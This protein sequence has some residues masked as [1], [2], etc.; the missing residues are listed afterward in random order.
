MIPIGAA[1]SEIYLLMGVK[2]PDASFSGVLG[3]TP[4][5]EIDSPERLRFEIRYADGLIDEAFPLALDTHTYQVHNGPD[6]YCIPNL[7]K[8]R[9]DSIA[10]CNRMESSLVSISAITLNTGKALARPPVPFALPAVVRETPSKGAPVHAEIRATASGYAIETRDLEFA[11][12]TSQ[13]IA[14]RSL[15]NHCLTGGDAFIE[16]G[17]LFELGTGLHVVA[18]DRLKTGTA[19]VTRNDGPGGVEG[20]VRRRYGGAPFRGSLICTANDLGPITLELE[21]TYTGQKP[22]ATIVNFPTFRGL[23]LGTAADTWYLWARKGGIIS[24][25]STHQAGYSGGEYPLQVADLFNP[26]LGGGLSLQTFDISG[27]YKQWQLERTA[28]VRIGGSITF[29]SSG[30]RGPWCRWPDVA[31]RPCGRLAGR[32]AELPRVDAELVSAGHGNEAMVPGVFQL[33]AA[34]GLGRVV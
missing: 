21:L 19:S 1:G 12:S 31:L 7:R 30:N 2:L 16:P 17:P 15:T 9:I 32:A 10:I 22:A 20:P 4:L 13:G 8:A 24:N 33:P 34:H 3:G 28:E 25:L 5:H 18:S 23:R 29:P 6:V 14:V 11:L 27:I 26:R